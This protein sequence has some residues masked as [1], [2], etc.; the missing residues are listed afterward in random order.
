MIC[1]WLWQPEDLIAR[2]R[3]RLT[4]NFTLDEWHRYLGD[5]PYR[6]LCPNLD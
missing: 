6:K 3:T 5:E 2:A 4:R 1:F